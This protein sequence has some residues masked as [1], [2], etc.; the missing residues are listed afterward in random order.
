MDSATPIIQPDS[1]NVTPVTP[2]SSADPSTA[3]AI[4]SGQNAKQMDMKTTISSMEDLKRKN[5]ELYKMMM[6]GIATGMISEMRRRQE[7]L[8]QMMREAR[9]DI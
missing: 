5:P 3:G 4:A 1:H 2:P 6:Q 7:R 9:R 8:K